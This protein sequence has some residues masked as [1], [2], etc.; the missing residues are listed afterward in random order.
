MTTITSV[1]FAAAVLG[2]FSISAAAAEGSALRGLKFPASAM[3]D[4]PVE[5]TAEPLAYD[6]RGFELKAIE[7]LAQPRFANGTLR[8]PRLVS[9]AGPRSQGLFYRAENSALPGQF[10]RTFAY[11]R[12]LAPRSA[13]YAEL[14]QSVGGGWGLGLVL[15]QRQ[16]DD[17]DARVLSFTGERMWGNV[18]GAYTLSAGR[19]EN[20]AAS[21]AHKFQF[22]YLY[23]DR[24]SV[25]MS[26]RLGREIDAP[27]YAYSYNLGDG[28]DFAVRGRHWFSPNWALTYDVSANSNTQNGVYSRQGLRLG[29]RHVF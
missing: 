27:L 8:P 20:A 29:L 22:D 24:S 10:G 23:G 9:L 2:G 5:N 12:D 6:V 15:A 3:P 18:R 25:G 4:S 17:T 16:Y 19:L 13:N 1:L 14:H 7:Q 21:S 28:R 26:Y 11:A